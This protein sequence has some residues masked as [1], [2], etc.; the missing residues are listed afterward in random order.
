MLR[1]ITSWV[2][3]VGTPAKVEQFGQILATKQSHHLLLLSFSAWQCR[4]IQERK[5]LSPDHFELL[6]KVRGACKTED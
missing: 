4:A 3:L 6:E 1:I 5:V 2:A